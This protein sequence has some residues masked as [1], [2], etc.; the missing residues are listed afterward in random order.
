MNYNLIN[1]VCITIHILTI[2]V[3]RKNWKMQAILH[4][5]FYFSILWTISTIS[6]WITTTVGIM[7]L[8]N[9]PAIY[10]LNVYAAFTSL[11]FMLTS[12]IGKQNYTIS[13]TFKLGTGTYDYL[14]VLIVLAFISTLLEWISS[15][16]SF[17]FSENRA[18]VLYSQSHIGRRYTLLD[19]VLAICKTTMPFV[20]IVIGYILGIMLAT[21]KA[22]ISKKWIALPIIIAFIDAMAQGGRIS[23]LNSLKN[24]I[25]GVGF[26]IPLYKISNKRVFKLLFYSVTCVIAFFAFISFVGESRAEYT[27]AEYSFSQFGIFGGVV[28]YMTSHYWGYQLRRIDYANNIDLYYGI[29]TFYGF[30]DFRI[31]FSASLGFNGNIWDMLG[32]EFDPLKIYK[33]GVEGSYTTSSQFMPLVADFGTKGAYVAIIV[34]V[35]LTQRLFLSIVRNRKKSALSLVFYYIFFCY[36]FGSNFNGGFMSLYTVF[37]AAVLFDVI[38]KFRVY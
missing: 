34:L 24:Y 27:G 37:L 4:P 15:G 19:S 20:T 29:N 17:S 13:D 35:C 22:L 9:E 25:I 28:D 33:S 8:P 30:L 18:D 38:R 12:S 36:W 10:E 5:G 6:Q 21:D 31:P 7:P 2:I 16:A 23:V 14:K 26:S 32:V 1:T 3:I 11:V